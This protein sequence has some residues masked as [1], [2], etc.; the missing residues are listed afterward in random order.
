MTPRIALAGRPNVG[1]STIFNRLYGRKKALV[2]DISG[3]TRDFR[4]EIITL[5]D[6]EF[7]LIDTA[8]VYESGSDN[9]SQYVEDNALKVIKDS[10]LCLFVVDAKSGL[11]TKDIELADYLR[12]SGVMTRAIVNKCES[13]PSSYNIF[14]FFE[15]GFGE[16]IAISAEH[17]IGI[18][19]LIEQ[20]LEAV[21]SNIINEENDFD[22]I[23]LA[24]IGKPNVGK[25]TLLNSLIGH[26]RMLTGDIAGITR[27][28]ISSDWEWDGKKI[29]LIDTAG[30][31]RKSKVYKDTEKLAY[32]DSIKTIK[33]SDIVILLIDS[34]DFIDKQDLR[35]ADQVLTEGRALL[36]VFNKID[37]VKDRIQ[38]DDE[39]GK[40]FSTNLIQLDKKN[41][42]KVSSLNGR[43]TKEMMEKVILLYNE[44][45][46]R[47]TTAKLNTWLN[48]AV[49]KH[50]PP[51]KAGRRV[52][53]RYITQASVKPPTF[54]VFSSAPDA[55]PS[56]YRKYL[57]NELRNAF[58]Y[59]LSPLRIYF[60]KGDNPY[61]S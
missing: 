3:L 19:N 14:E 44:W 8:G 53:L 32:F 33:Y 6:Q 50:Q 7:F 48:E 56:S 31:R 28:S 25:S 40:I 20:I 18:G 10:D 42:L 24:I 61:A 5:K 13:G 1:K 43:G 15:L 36:I 55:I 29:K 34:I 46:K 12:K 59:N 41:I 57:I 58:G 27:D 2:S 39:I 21:P 4:E 11:T 54:I 35:L 60:R 47:T 51:A 16:P 52:K 9:L 22:A 38:F 17:N 49:Q 45:T 37:L 26:E 23:N 30:L